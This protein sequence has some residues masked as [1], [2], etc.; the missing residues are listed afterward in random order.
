[1]AITASQSPPRRTLLTLVM[2]AVLG[3]A[4]AAA[5]LLQVSSAGRARAGAE[6]IRQ[7]RSRGL[8]H[9]WDDN[10]RIDWYLI[11]SGSAV[12]GWQA[13]VRERAEEGRFHGWKVSF[14]ADPAGTVR[15]TIVEEW[16]LNA[17]A[18]RGEYQGSVTVAG[19]EKLWTNTVL[20]DGD[21]R[22][23]QGPRD[24]PARTPAPDNYIPKGAFPLAVRQIASGRGDGQFKMV[25]DQKPRIRSNVQFSTVRIRHVGRG[26]TAQ[27][28]PTDLVRM[29]HR[30]WGK[31]EMTYELDEK[32][33]LLSIQTGDGLRWQAA[34]QEEVTRQFPDAPGRLSR[35][36]RP[37]ARGRP[38]DFWRRL[39]Q[40]LS[41][42]SGAQLLGPPDEFGVG[43]LGAPGQ[44]EMDAA[45]HTI[46]PRRQGA[47]QVQRRDV[48]DRREDVVV[49]L[50]RFVALG[51]LG[52]EDDLIVPV[53]GEGDGH[54]RPA[55]LHAGDVR[56][57]PGRL[58]GDG[59][60]S[61][62]A[63]GQGQRQEACSRESENPAAHGANLIPAG[64]SADK[65]KPAPLV[66]FARP[67][68]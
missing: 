59:Q 12:R 11:P 33:E 14:I 52:A 2:V 40:R 55:H 38:E 62:H 5:W 29:S 18:T 25:F 42:V 9:Y 57:R 49:G 58:G 68:L 44:G 39:F 8:S 13:M 24:V 64:P 3:A 53:P 32:G 37:P 17:D 21:V 36:A 20:D 7:I 4:A 67:I 10:P 56:Q 60:D 46:R 16:I 54:G 34:S 26:R 50:E 35:A 61:L 6:I 51:A 28:K 27:G 23:R 22:V 66:C 47:E 31:H 48:V 45:P 30:E 63:A 41:E 1:M 15:Q 43:R 19:F 65:R